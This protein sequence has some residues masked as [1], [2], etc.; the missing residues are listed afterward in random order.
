MCC[1][2]DVAISL[3][4]LSLSLKHWFKVRMVNG[5]QLNGTVPK[6]KDQ[7]M[8]TTTLSTIAVRAGEHASIV[9]ALL[10]VGV[11]GLIHTGWM[12]L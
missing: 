9:V 8:S 10:K 6:S 7:D 5:P 12:R 2:F 4:G 11:R 3:Q 1:L